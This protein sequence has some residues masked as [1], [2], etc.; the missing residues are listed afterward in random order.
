MTAEAETADAERPRPALSRGEWAVFVCL[1]A[2]NLV[3]IWAFPLSVSCA[4]GA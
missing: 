3:P 2:L 1:S 4:A